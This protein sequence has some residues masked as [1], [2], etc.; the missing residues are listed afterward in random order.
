MESSVTDT[1]KLLPFVPD[2]PY[3][4]QLVFFVTFSYIWYSAFIDDY[5]A[6]LPDSIEE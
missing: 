2:V 6:P 4:V 1:R 3:H 5:N